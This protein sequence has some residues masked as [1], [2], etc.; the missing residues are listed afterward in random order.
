MLHHF[1][2]YAQ[3]EGL[4]AVPGL[5]PKWIR[6]LLMFDNQGRFLGVQDFAGD[7][8]KKKGREF[9]ACPDF[10][11]SEMVAAGGG[12]RPFLVDNVEIVTLLS[13][14]DEIDAKLRA[15]HDYFV[16]LLKRAAA[17]IPELQAVAEV[18]S[19][20]AKCAPIRHELAEA[21]AKPTELVTIGIL[22]R[23]G[24]PRILVE[25]DR[26]HA[27]WLEFRAA[28]AEARDTKKR[29]K[30]GKE[31]KSTMVDF[32]SGELGEP[33]RTQPKVEGLS[34][35]GGLPTGDVLAGFDK[36][37]FTSYRLSQGANAAMSEESAK[38][39]VTALNHLI[40][41]RS[42]RLAGVKIA[43][44]YSGQVPDELDPAADLLKDSPWLPAEEDEEQSAVS[45][46]ERRQAE[47][48]AARALEAIRKG[49]P[50]LPDLASYRY[51]AITLSGNSGRVVV[52]DWMEGSFEELAQNV[53][54]WFNDLAIVHRDGQSVVRHF[55]FNA[56]LGAP[57]RDLREATAPLATAMWRCAVKGTPIPYEVMARTLGRV[58]ADFIQGNAPRH[59]RLGLLKAFTIR[60]EGVPNMSERLNE[61]EKN[62]AYISGRIM[63]VLAAIQ[64][65]ANPDVGSGVVQRYYAAASATPALILGRLVRT[66]QIAHL[67]QIEQEGLRYWFEKLLVDLWGK[68]D[69]PPPRILTLE[70]QTLFAMGYYHQ[71]AHRT[72]GAP[73]PGE[74]SQSPQEEAV[75]GSDQ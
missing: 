14:G 26:W 64:R 37:A 51:Y 61:L 5:K 59:A 38:T 9:L 8:K 15:K 6:W 28:L 63:A 54:A 16:D 25:D 40:Q 42:S 74:D 75:S 60:K 73:E 72:K 21:K 30:R 46:Q 22:D 13:K 31:A 10:T 65:R 18:L 66:A 3:T 24:S 12:C 33:Q 4:A 35:V 71:L 34:D 44:W 23:V 50:R 19:D 70:G 36:E 43:Y 68:L 55:K 69:G 58:R 7:D 67:P 57:L 48:R 52:R 39:Y 47:S 41:H 32:L 27:W 45:P 11:Q 2:E 49:E 20:E 17:A 62:P 56:V 53:N 1:V 29:P